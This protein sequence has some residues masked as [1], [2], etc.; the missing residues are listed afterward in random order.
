MNERLAARGFP[1]VGVARNSGP[2]FR[3]TEYMFPITGDQRNVVTIDC[4]NGVRT[5][6]YRQAFREAG[7]RPEDAEGYTWHH[8]DDYDPVTNTGAM[9]LV[10]TDVHSAANHAGGIAQYRAA[11]A[12]KG[13]N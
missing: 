12:N 5:T 10:R 4:G 7:I 11:L 9:Q 13:G 6:H 3:G 8:V 2:D 1:G